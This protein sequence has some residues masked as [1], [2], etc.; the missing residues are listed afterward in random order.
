MTV[1]AIEHTPRVQPAP[2]RCGEAHTCTKPREARERGAAHRTLS[3]VRRCILRSFDRRARAGSVQLRRDVCEP[4]NAPC[5]PAL[6]VER[7]TR[8][9]GIAR[10][11]RGARWR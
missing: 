6:V 2:G 11:Q 3:E 7:D 1:V 4:T 9:V 5:C 8:D 10:E